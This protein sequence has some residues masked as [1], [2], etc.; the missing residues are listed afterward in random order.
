[1]LEHGGWGEVGEAG[2]ERVGARWSPPPT[3]VLIMLILI[4][5]LKLDLWRRTGSGWSEGGGE[6]VAPTHFCVDH[7]DIDHIS[8]TGLVEEDGWE[9]WVTGGWGH[10]GR[11]H[12]LQ[13]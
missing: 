7:I 13:C 3:F 12:P 8:E 9:R 10:G 5:F 6:V 1:M 2:G 11:P 4:I